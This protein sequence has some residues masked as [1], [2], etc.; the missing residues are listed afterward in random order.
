MT[1]YTG[2]IGGD[3][4]GRHVSMPVAALHCDGE[5]CE[6]VLPAPSWGGE[7]D[8]VLDEAQDAGWALGDSED[9]RD[10]CPECARALRGAP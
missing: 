3:V 6:E 10:L 9:R 1:L 2:T 5:D 8:G 7:A 4:G